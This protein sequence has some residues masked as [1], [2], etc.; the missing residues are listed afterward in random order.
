M[1]FFPGLSRYRYR[2]LISDLLF[3]VADTSSNGSEQSIAG[4]FE[5]QECFALPGGRATDF[6]LRSLVSNQ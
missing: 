2:S 3:D 6:F 5:G 4:I 1:G